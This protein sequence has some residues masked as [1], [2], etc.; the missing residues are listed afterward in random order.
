MI[1]RKL[2]KTD[3]EIS[4]I[5]LGCSGYW[6]NKKFSEKKASAIVNTAFDKG[7]NFFDTGHNY[8][9]FNAEPRLGRI[10]KD[11]CRTNDRSKIVISSKG[12]SVIGGFN[13][14]SKKVKKDFSIDVIEK[15]I[16]KSISNLNC[17]YLDIFQLHGP[18]EEQL[19]D[20]FLNDLLKLKQKGLFRYLGAN[21]HEEKNM[22]FISKHPEIF[23]MVLIDYNV[24]QL[25]RN[26]FIE[27]LS[28]AGIG[29]VAGTVL[30]QGHL[31]KGK[32][33]SIKS[34][35]FFWYLLRTM[36]KSTTRELK[37]NSKFMKETLASIEEMSAAQAAFSYI[38][39][40][41]SISSCLFGTTNINN[42][43]EI[44][45]TSGQKISEEGKISI[46]DSFNKM[47]RK[48]SK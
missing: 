18:T 30:A 13:P 11:I 36:L 8:S 23:D 25:D 6:G 35:A 14:F 48:I 38:L 20:K 28:N 1:Y 44:I 46:L 22:E 29:V 32:N 34:G 17:D 21:I 24:L 42:L 39:E 5:A 19:N 26:P 37:D 41:N 12:G 4:E 45:E 40:N 31:I 7:V 16:Q 43:T 10:I 15:T 33:G 3:L 47:T 2:G 9:N 27:K